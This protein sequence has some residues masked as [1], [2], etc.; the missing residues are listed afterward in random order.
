M[1]R[2]PLGNGGSRLT[3]AAARLLP[4]ATDAVQKIVEAEANPQ[5]ATTAGVPKPA[6]AAPKAAPAAVP[7]AGAQ[8]AAVRHH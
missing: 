5:R 2:L 6:A 7:D 8:K 1:Q 4:K 3:A